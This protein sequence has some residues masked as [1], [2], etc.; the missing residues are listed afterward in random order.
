MDQLSYK[1]RSLK[2]EEV[3]RNWYVVDATGQ[4]IGR[5]ASKVAQLLRGK[6]KPEY[7]PHV[8][9]GD[10]IIIVN[11]EKAEFTGNKWRDKE[12]RWFTGY[13]SGGRSIS[14]E[15]MHKRRPNRIIEKAVKNMLPKNRLSRKI[16][17]NNLFINEGPDHQHEA[18]KPEALDLDTIK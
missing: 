3:K 13:P 9:C 5:L 10:K 18:Q 14:A 11:A 15:D 12:Y 8:D 16:F 6:H 17:R 4:S 7:T 2:K 1:T